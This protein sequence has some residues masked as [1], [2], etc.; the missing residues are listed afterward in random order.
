MAGTDLS[1]PVVFVS[2]HAKAGGAE[3]YLATLVE[4]LGPAWVR[5][6]VCLE[7][8]PL[9]ERLRAEGVPVEV[10]PTSRHSW[11]IVGSARRLRRLLGREQPAVVHANGI[12]AALVSVL[13][14]GRPIV[15][16][17]HDFSYDG[18]LARFVAGRCRL[19]VGVSEAVTR[20]FPDRD[21]IEVVHNGLPPG[22]VDRQAGRQRLE[23]ALGGPAGDVVALVGRL[24][25]VKGHR[26]LLAVASQVRA[27][28]PD[29]RL[30]FVGGP[31]S[32]HAGYGEEL[33]RE[34]GDEASFL[35]HRE[36][37]RELIA[38]ADLLAIPTVV[39]EGFPYVGL[40]AL[41]AGTPVVGY[42]DGGL[43]ELVGPCGRLVPPGDRAALADAI[44]SLL[45]DESRRR[46]L[47]DCGRERVARE[48]ALD[49]MVDAMRNAY[50]RAAAT[51]SRSEARSS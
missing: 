28:R 5:C 2:S 51:R 25:P 11:G 44:V 1:V 17:K 12:K 7:D 27:K 50:R 4:S 45:E 42:A 48:F 39:P 29:L 14:T 30:V 49:R 31:D 3:G 15:W 22:V 24:D 46:E 38:G 23:R 18:P 37:A 47:G 8:G 35:G 21:R 6:V 43:P 26:E 32:S 36:D 9:V 16:A 41:A 33:R 19:V 20:T 13:S 10:L 34:A 40:E